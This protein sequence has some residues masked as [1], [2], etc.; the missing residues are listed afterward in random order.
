[1]CIAVF[2]WLANADTPLIVAAN[3]DEFYARPSLPIHWWPDTDLL[4]GRDERNGGTWMGMT[5][6]GRF[7]LIT[8][9][10][11]PALRKP[12]A[13]SRGAIVR[14]FLLGD[15]NT[16]AFLTQLSERSHHYEGFNLVCAE[17]TRERRA[18]WFFNSKE[19]AT[20]ALT[21]GVFALSNAS[22]DTPWPKIERVKAAFRQALARPPHEHA[23]ALTSLLQDRTRAGDEAL[24]HT[25]V[26]LE[27]ERA[28]S[29][30]FIRYGDYGTRA[31]TQLIVRNDSFELTE[32]THLPE[33]EDAHRVRFTVPL[34]HTKQ[35]Y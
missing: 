19:N 6:G 12:G 9:V 35:H 30:I 27:W 20:R 11:D 15:S 21:D 10:R 1:M 14:D 17:L 23:R 16:E 25:G 2:Q 5:R 33:R 29:S 28:L 18:L 26:P 31:S 24:P 22:L 8:N 32:Q 34:E 13:P 7:A 4:A 3:R